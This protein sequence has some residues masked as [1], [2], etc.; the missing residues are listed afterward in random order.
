MPD[1]D[2]RPAPSLIVMLTHNDYTADNAEEIFEQCRDTE[3]LYWGFKE[4]P[5]TETRMK[6]LYRR[7]KECGKTTVLEVVSYDEAA[8]L[9]GARLGARCGCDMLMGTRFFPSI[10]RFCRDHGLRYLPFIG[11]ITGRPSVLTGSID[12]II[13]EARAALEGGA[14]GIDLLGYRYEGDAITLNKTVTRDIKADVCIAGSVD[15]YSRLD[16]IREAAPRFF[17][18]GSAFFNNRF[19]TDFPTQINNV[20]RYFR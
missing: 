8:G 20:C 17:T 11:T 1:N 12:S 6:N 18:I 4:L 14:D 7:M 9:N 5:L 16:E 3:A 15:S 10:A 13:A 2:T 19:G